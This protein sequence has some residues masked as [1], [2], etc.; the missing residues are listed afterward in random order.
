MELILARLKFYLKIISN[1]ELI[2]A[3]LKLYLKI[4][5]G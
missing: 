5:F 2:L 3:S 4:N 1:M